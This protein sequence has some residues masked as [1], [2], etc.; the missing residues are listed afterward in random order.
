MGKPQRLKKGLAVA[1]TAQS[2]S[3]PDNDIDSYATGSVGSSGAAEAVAE[4]QI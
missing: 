3:I 4:L 2:K 1:S